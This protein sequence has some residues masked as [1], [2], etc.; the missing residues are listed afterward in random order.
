MTGS[1]RD[2]SR[3]SCFQTQTSAKN[4]SAQPNKASKIPTCDPPEGA[5]G[6]VAGRPL[7][8]VFVDQ[9]ELVLVTVLHVPRGACKHTRQESQTVCEL[10]QRS[11]QTRQPA[12]LVPVVLPE[13]E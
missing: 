8:V 12:G 10:I 7:Q 3:T 2:D 13:T 1:L 9:L 11:H 6:H 4:C 5:V